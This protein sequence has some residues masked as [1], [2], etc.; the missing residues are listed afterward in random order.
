[1]LRR[2]V[3][4]AGKHRRPPRP[5]PRLSPPGAWRGVATTATTTTT[6]GASPATRTTPHAVVDFT[7]TQ[8]AYASLSTSD[9]LRAY[10]VFK[11]CAIKPLVAHADQLL[12]ASYR[13]LG[14]TLTGMSQPHHTAAFSSSSSPHPSHLPS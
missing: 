2:L 9:L 8:T 5:A 3:Q 7:D 14:T 1:M 12:T 11:A 6:T 13:V 10:L 4:Q